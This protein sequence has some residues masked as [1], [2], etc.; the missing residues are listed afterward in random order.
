M[1]NSSYKPP[2]DAVVTHDLA[3]P[4][5]AYGGPVTSLGVRR[6]RLADLVAVDGLGDSHATQ[7]LIQHCCAIPFTAAGLLDCE[8]AEVLSGIITGFRKKSPKD[9]SSS[10]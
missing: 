9:G 10:S 8:D 4:I 3:H 7:V 2:P 5:E 1:G 6:P